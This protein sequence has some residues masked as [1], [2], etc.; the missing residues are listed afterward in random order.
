MDKINKTNNLITCCLE[1][2]YIEH[3]KIK[4]KS[5]KINKEIKTKKASKIPEKE[6]LLEQIS[7]MPIT[8]VGELYG[9]SGNAV[10]KWA[11]KYE[12]FEYRLIKKPK[13][14]T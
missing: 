9:V 12:I 10:K 6:I 5:C 4:K 3:K 8:K 2:H 1:C 7:T 14:K 13:K 11:I